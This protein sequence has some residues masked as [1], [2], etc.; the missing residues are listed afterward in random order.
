MVVLTTPIINQAAKRVPIQPYTEPNE[1]FVY[2]DG[3]LVCTGAKGWDGIEG[4]SPTAHRLFRGDTLQGTL[5]G[6]V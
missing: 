6:V 3:V 4:G 5:A 1:P 2:A